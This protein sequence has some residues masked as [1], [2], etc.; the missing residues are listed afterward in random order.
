[1]ASIIGPFEVEDLKKVEGSVGGN[2]RNQS[3]WLSAG[4]HDACVGKAVY[5]AGIYI[6]LP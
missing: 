3:L 5:E 1:M 4:T 6:I 2:H